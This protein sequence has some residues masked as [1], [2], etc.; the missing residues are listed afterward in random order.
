MNELLKDLRYGVR[1]LYKTRGVSLVAIVTI[2]LGI[3]AVTYQ[4][5][6]FYAVTIRGLPFEDGDRLVRI[7]RTIVKDG[8]MGR[9]V[10]L[11]DFMD[12]REQQ[13]VF[14]D[15]AGFY[16]ST[17]NLGDADQRPERYFGTFVTANIF[18]EVN[19]RPLMGRAFRDDEKNGH[20][21]PTIVLGHSVW[22]VRYRGDPDIIGKV[23]R[24][25]GLAATVIGVMPAGFRFPLENDLWMPS[26]S[27]I[28]RCG[29]EKAFAY[30]LLGDSRKT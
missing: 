24:A 20:I 5:S 26:P 23:V 7:S 18:S 3:G 6:T 10:L 21:A 29:G 17:I 12:W 27:I 30:G 8:A 11:H 28:P 1:M 22:Q 4:F 14:E 13:T 25:N 15:L 16:F 2:A 19:T 9:A